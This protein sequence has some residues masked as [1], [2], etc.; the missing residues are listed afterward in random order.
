MKK[1]KIIKLCANCETS[2]K[3]YPRRVKKYNYCSTKCCA[4][5][6]YKIG[7]RNGKKLTEK[8]HQYI[9]DNGQP[10]NAG[11][12]P[13]WTILIKLEEVCKKISETKNERHRLAG[14]THTSYRGHRYNEIKAQVKARDRDTC[15]KCQMT[16]RVHFE[17][18]GQPLQVDHIIPYSISR[19]SDLSNLQTLC[20]SCHGKKW[21]HDLKLVREAKCQIH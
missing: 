2:I 15:T 12:P 9:R 6:Q 14:R 11:R 13:A 1:N 10:Q 16:E 20:C 4:I 17:K 21:K 8:A 18:F 3:V 5:F 19:N 7:Q